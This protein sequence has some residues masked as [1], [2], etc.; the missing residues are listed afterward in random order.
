MVNM[1]FR[2]NMTDEFNNPYDI[3]GAY[4]KDDIDAYRR[5]ISDCSD[6]YWR[7]ECSRIGCWEK[8]RNQHLRRNPDGIPYFIY[9]PAWTDGSKGERDV[10]CS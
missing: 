2:L 10:P 9:A 3:D 6:C 4:A 7:G 1:H 5:C 8:C